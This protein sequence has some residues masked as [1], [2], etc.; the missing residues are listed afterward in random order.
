MALLRYPAQ[1]AA[2]N[3]SANT[4]C[5]G[6]DPKA[7]CVCRNRPHQQGLQEMHLQI[8]DTQCASRW[9]N[10]GFTSEK[11][12]GAPMMTLTELPVRASSGTV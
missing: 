2:A 9:A 3:H 4:R 8:Y 1:Q 12:C 6:P 11:F 7:G 10:L 5:F